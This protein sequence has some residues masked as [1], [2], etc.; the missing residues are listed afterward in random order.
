[1]IKSLNIRNFAVIESVGVEFQPG[2]N[3]LTGETGS[4]K[5]IVVDALGLLL[6][7]RGSTA[8]I[9][10]G[11]SRAF[12]EGIFALDGEQ[13]LKIRAVL[14]E[15]GIEAETEDEIIIRREVS[16]SGKSRIYIN[17][18]SV[19]LAILRRLQPLLVE[20]HGQGE[21]KLLLNARAQLELLDA[22]AGC[23]GLRAEVSGAFFDWKSSVAA[24]NKLKE[25]FVERERMLELLEYQ[26]SEI[27]AISPEP[28]ED[29]R[30]AN[31][32]RLLAHA[33]KILQLGA[34]AYDRLYESDGSVLADLSG[35]SRQVRELCE[36]DARLQ[37]LL[38]SLDEGAALLS[39]AAY[40]LRR[41]LD[42]I[43]FK[44]EEFSRVD[45]RLSE[46]ERLKRK[47]GTDLNGILSIREHIAQKLSRLADL[48][49]QERQLKTEFDAAHESYLEKAAKLSARRKEAA[50]RLEREVVRDLK[51]VAMQHAQFV[52]ELKTFESQTASSDRSS[53]EAELRPEESALEAGFFSSYGADR[54]SFLLSAN[55]G[56]SLRPLSQAASGGELSRMMLTLLTVSLKH[57]EQPQG[58]ETI[59]F[60]EIDVGIGG[61]VAEAVGRRLKTLAKTNQV[62]C[63][64]HQAQIAR[65]ADA[66]YSVA[67]SVRGG[68]TLTSI[69]YL[70][71][72]ARIRELA[73]MIAGEQESSTT[74][75]TARWMLE[76]AET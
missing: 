74:F 50:R 49:E 24:L 42:N 70:E 8:Q 34:G 61:R 67:K 73:R 13:M 32:R 60:D 19:T 58:G 22:Y 56:E 40:A 23:E 57:T 27:D 29:E 4:G 59:I 10:T 47:F 52:V 62:L 17:D 51:H 75:E 12:I 68:R 55:P 16:A 44:P 25:E 21:Q 30:L 14:D 63:V 35:I 37:P 26:L 45:N 66:H 1:M 64:T 46:L 15:V 7:E 9:R 38:N 20:I 28:G 48:T 76:T 33:E 31:E 54:I 11:E 53:E 5:S 65:F 2:L 43:E 39:D 72:E 41:Y 71:R 36:I 69:E 3:L 18:R 6:G